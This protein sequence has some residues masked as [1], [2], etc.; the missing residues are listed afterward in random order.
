MT[1][2]VAA[3]AAASAWWALPPPVRWTRPTRTGTTSRPLARGLLAGLLGLVTAMVFGGGALTAVVTALGA[4]RLLG[5][6]AAA[7]VRREFVR[8]QAE[9][10]SLVGLIALGLRAG[11]AIPE[12]VAAA[13]EALPGPA[14]QRLR[15]P[16]AELTLGADPAFAWAS[17]AEDPVLAP[18]GRALAR[19][20]R[21]GAP[22]ADVLSQLADDLAAKARLEAE[23][24]ARAVGVKAAL[25]LG[26]CFLPAFLALG[27]IPLVAGLV[28][29]LDWG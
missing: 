29:A 1:A 5:V 13:A 7:A 28:G 3:L 12:A 25:P 11:M 15:S 24:R 6:A 9:L 20:H 8:T 22:V 26:V 16:V 4:W 17:L 21:S 23:E 27:I 14:A 19:V 2:L 18:L 10:S